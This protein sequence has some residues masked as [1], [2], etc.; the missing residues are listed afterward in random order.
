ML[1]I[2]AWRRCFGHA[3]IAAHAKGRSRMTTTNDIQIQSLSTSLDPLIEHFNTHADN[4][5]LLTVL[6]P[7]CPR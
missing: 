5:R 7:M 4:L 1:T 6:S 2:H 3:E